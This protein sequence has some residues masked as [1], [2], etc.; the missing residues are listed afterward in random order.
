MTSELNTLHPY[1]KHLAKLFLQECINEDIEVKII[2]TYRTIDEQD[3]LYSLGRSIPGA[4]TT[5]IKGG[6]SHHNYGL[7][8]DALP[9]IDGNTTKDRE[10]I[11][12]KM[13]IIAKSLGLTWGGEF[14]NGFYEPEHF[15]WAGEFSIPKAKKKKRYLTSSFSLMKL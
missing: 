1:V 2:S 6:Y 4:I 11:L 14:K 9:V 5:N 13:G 10:D 7:A 12:N 3:E 15:E 8:F